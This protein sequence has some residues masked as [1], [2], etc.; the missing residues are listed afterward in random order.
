MLKRAA[1]KPNSEAVCTDGSHLAWH[2]TPTIAKL[3]SLLERMSGKEHSIWTNWVRGCLMQSLP[4]STWVWR[5]PESRD[6]KHHDPWNKWN[7]ISADFFFTWK[8]KNCYQNVFV[9]GSFGRQLGGSLWAPVDLLNT[10][11]L[12]DIFRFWLLKYISRYF[13]PPVPKIG[14]N[15][16]VYH[17][18]TST[19]YLDSIAWPCWKQIPVSLGPRTSLTGDFSM[20]HDPSTVRNSWRHLPTRWRF[21]PLTRSMLTWT[22]CASAKKHWMAS[23]WENLKFDESYQK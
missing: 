21:P 9:L 12:L 3:E 11:K 19:K 5:R 23:Q 18:S 4:A 2:A 7:P 20:W 6:H 1:N 13:W 16:E 8:L 15:R 14:Q 10:W 17:F 22:F